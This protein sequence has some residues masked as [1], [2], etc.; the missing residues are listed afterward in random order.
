MVEHELSRKVLVDLPPILGIDLSITNEVVLLWCSATATFVLVTLACRRRGVVAKGCLANAFEAVVEFLD[1][2]V[3][4]G[5]IGKGGRSWA[6]FLLSLFFFILFTNLSGMLP[7]PSHTKAMTSDLSVTLALAAIVFVT[8]IAA[9]I[10]LHGLRGFLRKFLPSGVPR[11]VAAAIVPIEVVSWLAKPA[12]LAIRLFANM[13]AGHALILVF[14]VLAMEAAWLLSFLPLAGAV[15]M[16][17]FELFVC[18]IQAFI[19][20]ML[21][22]MYIKEAID[23]HH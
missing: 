2:E 15:I 20:T 22:G 13:M 8:T 9:S 14:I 1:N 23:V 5:S 4:K 11:A 12:S 6:P 3:I 19:F 21:T 18:F 16:S 17:A 7:F 10:R